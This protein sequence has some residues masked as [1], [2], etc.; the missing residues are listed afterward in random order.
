VLGHILGA[1]LA[2]T[3]EEATQRALAQAGLTADA[4]EVVESPER[5]CGDVQGAT[6]VLHVCL[7]L[8]A[9]HGGPCLILTSGTNTHIAII[10][11]KQ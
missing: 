9:E 1:E 3:A 6:T 10:V 4:V 2:A 7:A 8:L 11:Q 5:L